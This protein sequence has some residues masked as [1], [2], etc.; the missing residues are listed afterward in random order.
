MAKTNISKLKSTNTIKIKNLKNSI[1]E[2]K[3]MNMFTKSID[4]KEK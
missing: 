2:I 1:I 3:L 4:K